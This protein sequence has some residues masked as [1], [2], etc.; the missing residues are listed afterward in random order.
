MGF[1]EDQILE[2]IGMEIREKMDFMGGTKN[3]AQRYYSSLGFRTPD[4]FATYLTNIRAGLIMGHSGIQLDPERQ[5]LRLAIIF[6]Y[7]K[8]G[9]SSAAVK[10]TKSIKPEFYFPPNTFVIPIRESRKKTLEQ[11]AIN[12]K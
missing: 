11:R 6:H 9:E 2:K 8:F 5:L 7:L 1:S 4:S 10:Y 3:F 12:Y